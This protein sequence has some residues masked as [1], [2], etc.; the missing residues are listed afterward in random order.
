MVADGLGLIHTD[1]YMAAALQTCNNNNRHSCVVQGGSGLDGVPAGTIQ[2]Q[3]LCTS[4]AQ[5]GIPVLL[6]S[7]LYCWSHCLG[8]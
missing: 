3:R 8:P 6:E 2:L 1:L 7:P 5:R 4:T